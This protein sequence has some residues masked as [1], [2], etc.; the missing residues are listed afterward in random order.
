[1]QRA[2]SRV[3]TD[4]MVRASVAGEFVLK[5]GHFLA[6]NELRAFQDAG[7]RGIDLGLDG[8]ILC[9][10]ICKR[11]HCATPADVGAGGN[12]TKRPRS[13]MESV[14]ASSA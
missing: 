2:G 12:S 8:V 4:G 13:R 5:G 9:L 11:N 6:E 14:A 7:D 1:M 3:H 10:Q